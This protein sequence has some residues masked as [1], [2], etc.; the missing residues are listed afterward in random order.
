MM[1]GVVL[2]MENMHKRGKLDL[3]VFLVYLNM[4][5]NTKKSPFG[6][7]FVAD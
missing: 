5:Y 3:S 1:N 6:P 2:D 4:A 7:S